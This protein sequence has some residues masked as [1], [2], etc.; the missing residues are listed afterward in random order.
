[1]DRIQTYKNIESLSTKYFE[2]YLDHSINKNL[3]T[4]DG[5]LYSSFFDHSFDRGRLDVL[6]KMYCTFTVDALE[7]L[8]N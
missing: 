6:S 2:S 3:K 7:D 1:M 8:C 5:K 4:T